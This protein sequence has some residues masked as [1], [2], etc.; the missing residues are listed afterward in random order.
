MRNEN[1][2]VFLRRVGPQPTKYMEYTHPDQV[3]K[4]QSQTTQCYVEAKTDERFQIHVRLLHGFRY[5]TAS[6]IEIRLWLDAHKEPDVYL[7]KKVRIPADGKKHFEYT[8][9]DFMVQ[10]G[11]HWENGKLC[12]GDV[13]IGRSIAFFLLPKRD[14]RTDFVLLPDE[15]KDKMFRRSE[16]RDRS[17][18]L[19]TITVSVQ[20]GRQDAD[21]SNMAEPESVALDG[22]VSPADHLKG[23]T[24]HVK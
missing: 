7:C 16:L 19:G 22:V 21:P 11:D 14:S 13:Q 20:R 18:K 1:I 3:R 6:C 15:D 2:E 10:I 17:N 9:K 4:F 8:L 5:Y 24:H 23:V 12:F